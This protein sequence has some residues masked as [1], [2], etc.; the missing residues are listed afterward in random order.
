[1]RIL[2]TMIAYGFPKLSLHEELALAKRLG[3]ETLEILPDWPSLPSPKALARTTADQ[4]FS[5]W[6]A[7]GCW[8]GVTIRAARVDLSHPS[9]ATRRASVDDLKRCIDW[10]EEA[11]GSYLVVHPGGLS[12]P[13]EWAVRREGLA[14]GLIELAGHAAT[15]RVTICVENM[16][17]GVHPGSRMDELTT[18]LVEIG[19]PR[20]ALALDTG[21]AHISADL[22]SETL[23][24]GS[25]LVTTHVHDNNGRSDTHDPPGCGSIDWMHWK[26]A[27][28]AIGY[29]GVLMLECIRQIRDDPSSY[30]AEVLEPLLRMEG[31]GRVAEAQAVE[32]TV[33][34]DCDQ[35]PDLRPPAA[36]EGGLDGR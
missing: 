2:G 31:I 18:L 27:L 14:A 29:R 4:G 34:I 30:R 11:G 7:H 36:K 10:L 28:D 9:A 13:E 33:R 6:S 15:G 17:P 20:L 16:P 12:L 22:P 19:H 23:A 21:H 32:T 26:R 25:L 24:A 35:P 5:I 1:M 3:A 8:G